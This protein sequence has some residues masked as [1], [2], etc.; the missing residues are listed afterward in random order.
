MLRV[1]AQVLRPVARLSSVAA[2]EGD[3][4]RGRFTGS[5]FELRKHILHK[6]SMR[7][8]TSLETIVSLRLPLLCDVWEYSMP[9]KPLAYSAT[10]T[11]ITK[12]VIPGPRHVLPVRG[13][14]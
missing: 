14:L 8:E 13:I 6:D 12:P 10:V 9:L 2:E 3:W 1:S 11:V 5:Y 4:V 7:F